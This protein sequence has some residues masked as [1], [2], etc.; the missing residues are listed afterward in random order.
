MAGQA[1]SG[2]LDFTLKESKSY[3]DIHIELYGGSLVRWTERHTDSSGRYDRHHATHM[4]HSYSHNPH[5]NTYIVTY[6]S[7]ETYVQQGMLL[8]NS[9]Q[10]PHG[11]IGP[12]TYSLPFQFML[13][14]TCPGSFQGE[15]GSIAYVLRG[16]IK[17][18]LLHNDHKIEVPIQVQ[19]IIDVNLPH[20]LVPV[21]QSKEKHVGLI[22]CGSSIVFTVS[23]T[24]TCFCIGQ[25][26]PLTV[27]VVNGSSRRIKMRAAILRQCT[28][29]AQG[30]TKSSMNT[31]VAVVSPNIAAHSDHHIWNA[32]N[33]QVPMVYPSLQE[34]AI[35]KI[36]YV[37]SITA[38]IPWATSSQVQIPITL[39][40]VPF[41]QYT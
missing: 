27:S 12:G 24:R 26:L 23:L 37:L 39:G 36:Q 33:L 29:H 22:C 9:R 38:V 8:W 13:P 5:T 31:T 18:G 35:I 41:N 6:K 40:N 16:H 34:S 1:V 25:N 17:T 30:R 14:S 2:T 15:H 32:E 20:F 3:K 21:Q 4:H 7:S 11:K 28:Y 19:R 10:S